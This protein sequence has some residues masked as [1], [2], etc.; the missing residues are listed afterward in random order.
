MIQSI[1]AFYAGVGEYVA[2]FELF[3]KKHALEGVAKADHICYKCGSKESF[4][5]LRELFEPK[6]VSVYIY[7]A[8][9]SERRIAYIKLKKSIETSIGTIEF[10]EL[11]D[12]KLNGS[13]VDGFDHIELYPTRI[14]YDELVEQLEMSERVTKV[15]RLH[16]T[17]H[18]IDTGGGF[19]A[20]LTTGPLI[21]KIKTRE[22]V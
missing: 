8:M 20:R 19:L 12:Q 11:S 18:D 13:Q 15:E 2:Q 16:H 4:E 6:D 21:E 22:M 10:L 5:A 9:I 17:T 1:E 14:S 3:V 7:Q